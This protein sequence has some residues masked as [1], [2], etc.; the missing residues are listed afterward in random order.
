MSLGDRIKE[1]RQF[2]KWTLK[3]LGERIGVKDNTV[4][5]W[6]M[7]VRSPNLEMVYIQTKR[8]MQQKK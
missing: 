6:E 4:S 2:K 5:G 3:E 1:L 8:I 7:G